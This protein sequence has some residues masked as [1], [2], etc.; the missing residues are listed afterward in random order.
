MIDIDLILR[1]RYLRSQ[2][3]SQA[4]F[5]YSDKKKV[6]IQL[7]DHTETYVGKDRD[8]VRAEGRKHFVIGLITAFEVYLADLISSYIDSGKDVSPELFALL[9]R[10]GKYSIQEVSLIIKNQVTF[11]ELLRDN[12]NFQNADEAF[13]VLS[14]LFGTDFQKCIQE[15]RLA[16]KAA[17]NWV[18]VSLRKDFRKTISKLLSA[19]HEYIHDMSFKQTPPKKDI[20]RY[21]LILTSLVICI[22]MLKEKA[23][24]SNGIKIVKK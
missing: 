17:G 3:R 4:Y 12:A 11:A 18:Y 19:R 1:R 5:T 20:L 9:E 7:L 23:A 21:A 22:D 15:N 16:F 13:K 24:G 10:K 6:L 8:R 2:R 14:A